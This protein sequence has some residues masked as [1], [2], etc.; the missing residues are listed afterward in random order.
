MCG[1]VAISGGSCASS[2]VLLGLMNLQHRGQDGAGILSLEKKEN[3]SGNHFHLDKQSGLVSLGDLEDKVRHRKDSYAL[4]H[5]RYATVGGDAVE[6][7]QPFLI[8]K[9]GIGLAHNGNIVNFLDME[10]ELS[11][12]SALRLS[13]GRWVLSDSFML[14]AQLART[15]RWRDWN[16]GAIFDAVRSVMRKASGSFSVVSLLD[17]GTLFGFRDPHGIRPLFWGSRAGEERTEYGIASEPVAL[18]YLGFDSITEVRAGEAIVVSPDGQFEARIID[19]KPVKQCMFEW[20]Y[21]SRVESEFGGKSVYDVRFR[22]GIELGKR[23]KE[24]GLE[25]D[26]VV[27]VPETSRVSAIALAEYLNLPFREVLVKNRYV[28]RT[29]ILDSQTSRQE[30]IRR[31]LF[32]I[33][34]EFSGKRCLIVDDSIVRGNTARQI[35]HLVRESGASEVT[36]LSACPSISYPCFY[37]IDFPDKAELLAG[38]LDNEAICTELGAD[39]VI[40]QTIEGLSSAIGSNDLCTGCLTG[41]YPTDVALADRFAAKRKVDRLA[42]GEAPSVVSNASKSKSKDSRRS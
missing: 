14:L 41:T 12:D 10:D 40:F 35:T 18:S 29:F 13:S 16:S 38:H 11:R 39:R 34:S 6:M 37:G 21:F 20:V 5:T 17:N 3:G 27:P 2:E 19:E 22:L 8:E 32:P 25:A 1:I 30:A 15:L 42:E 24:M 36:L 26:I 4:G 7:L 28:N 31:K 33:A 9:F 23:V